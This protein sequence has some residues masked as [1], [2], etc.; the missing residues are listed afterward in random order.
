MTHQLLASYCKVPENT[1]KK[2]GLMCAQRRSLIALFVKGLK[3]FLAPH[4]IL[5][6]I[7]FCGRIGLLAG[8]RLADVAQPRTLEIALEPAP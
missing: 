1:K 5:S 7:R 3:I 4:P 2:M 6:F 8:L